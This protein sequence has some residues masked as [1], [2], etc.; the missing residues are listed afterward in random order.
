MP[1]SLLAET[2]AP[3]RGSL[4]PSVTWDEWF[5][6][7]EGAVRCARLSLPYARSA[8]CSFGIGEIKKPV[9]P[10]GKPSRHT[11]RRRACVDA[12]GGD[13]LTRRLALGERAAQLMRYL[14]PR[15]QNG[16]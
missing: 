10:V 1:Q 4:L 6:E 3:A 9:Q 5:E 7:G 8:A 12:A 16:H 14:R 15:L 13:K 11:S 2:R